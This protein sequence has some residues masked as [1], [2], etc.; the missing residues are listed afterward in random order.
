MIMENNHEK[1]KQYKKGMAKEKSRKGQS[2]QEKM[3]SKICRK[4]AKICGNNYK[5]IKYI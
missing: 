5:Q 2:L 4:K 1:V 3:L